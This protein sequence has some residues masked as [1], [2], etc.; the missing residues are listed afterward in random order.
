[1]SSSRPA[2]DGAR[3]QCVLFVGM[4]GAGKST[5]ANLLAA[6]LG[7]PVVDTDG[8]VERRAGATVAEVFDRE[9]EPAFR[10]AEAQAISELAQVDEPLVVSVGGGAVL[11]EANRSAMRAA[12]TVVWLRARPETLAARV[13][14]GRARPLLHR[15]GVTPQAALEQLAVEREVFYRDAADLTVDVD[16]LSAGQAADLVISALTSALALDRRA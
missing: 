6:R 11:S 1:L 9:G 14:S 12:G 8:M 5:V 3:R 16:D 4:M 2:A 10:A 13:G 7:W 15:S